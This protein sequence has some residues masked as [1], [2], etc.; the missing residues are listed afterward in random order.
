M[1]LVYLSPVPWQSFAQRPQKFVEWF[2]DR[3]AGEVLWVDPYPTRLPRVVDCLRV[4]RESRGVSPKAPSWLKILTPRALP[5]EPLPVVNRINT[6][7]WRKVFDR[8]SVFASEGPCWIGVGKPSRLA[9]RVLNS[10]PGISSFYDVMDDFSAF[11]SGWSRSAM[12][13]SESLLLHRVG[14]VLVSSS[15]S[16]NRMRSLGKEVVPVPNGCDINQ[17]PLVSALPKRPAQPVLGYVGTIGYW[18][19][20]SMVISLARNNPTILL[21]LIG[22]VHQLASGP[23]PENVELRPPCSH[24]EAIQAI[25]G[26]SVG[27]IP[28]KQNALTASVDPIKYYEYRALGLPVISTSFGEMVN[29]WHEPGVFLVGEGHDLDQVVRAALTFRFKAGEIEAFRCA[30]SWKV[31]FD[32]SGILR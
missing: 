25:Q 29:R 18:F 5:I 10:V 27:L 23:L 6:L 19:N 3:T 7:L 14:N 21:R 17:L 26:F 11:Y 2:H 1:R 20:W 31:R 13:K 12:K 8:T 28:F 24:A 4:D 9:L 22:P 30:N 32:A 16:L 15:T